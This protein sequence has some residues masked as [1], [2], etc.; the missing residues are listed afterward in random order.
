MENNYNPYSFF[1]TD[2]I[3]WNGII[4]QYGS[5]SPLICEGDNLRRANEKEVQ[6]YSVTH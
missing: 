3:V 1:H 2:I 6:L 5:V 4:S